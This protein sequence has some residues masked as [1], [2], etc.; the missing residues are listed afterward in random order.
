MTISLNESAIF[1]VSPVHEPGSR[2]E[3]SPS[4]MACIRSKMSTNSAEPGSVVAATYPLPFVQSVRWLACRNRLHGRFHRLFQNSEDYTH[5]RLPRTRD[6]TCIVP[7]RQW[8]RSVL[9]HWRNIYREREL[10]ERSGNT[11]ATIRTNEG[12]LE[13]WIFGRWSSYRLKDVK[14]V[15]VEEWLRS[16][17]L[18]NGSKAKIH[19]LMLYVSGKSRP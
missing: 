5:T 12:Y 6:K 9:A 10:Y 7:Q 18:A 8:T 19:N 4:R 15:I 11:F 3:K 17:P 1:P 14:A 16:W 13:R 2:T